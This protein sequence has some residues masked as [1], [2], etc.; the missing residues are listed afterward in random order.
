M[1]EN[2]KFQADT[3]PNNGI[4]IPTLV[5]PRWRVY[6]PNRC[7]LYLYQNSGT[8]NKYH[9]KLKIIC[10]FSLLV[11]G[12]A[13]IADWFIFCGQNKELDFATLKTKY[14]NRFPGWMQHLYISEIII[15]TLFFGLCFAVS[16]FIFVTAS[17]KRYK[18]L[19]AIAF[20]FAFWEL[21]SLM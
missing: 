11:T 12:L 14:G 5:C 1:K 21:F 13:S 9:L 10:A 16:G 3:L 7:F 18:V 8:P 15:A 2:S 17:H 20:L 4:P 6:S 19:G